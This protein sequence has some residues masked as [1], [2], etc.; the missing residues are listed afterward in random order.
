MHL[1]LFLSFLIQ[2]KKNQSDIPLPSLPAYIYHE[3]KYN[4][5]ANAHIP[6][7]N[8]EPKKMT[9]INGI[10]KPI[11]EKPSAQQSRSETLSLGNGQQNVNLALK[12]KN[13]VDKPLLNLISK[14]VSAHLSYP[15]IAMDFRLRGKALVG[16]VIYP[17]GHLTDLTLLQSSGTEVL[18]QAAMHSV[19]AIAPLKNVSFYLTKPESLMMGI[20]F[21]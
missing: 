13:L 1:F 15:K 18:D 2:F 17:D 11:P 5:L 21:Q 3:E 8:P 20:I 4:P 9:S 10:E 16:F 7:E 6:I 12:S 19:S 14:A